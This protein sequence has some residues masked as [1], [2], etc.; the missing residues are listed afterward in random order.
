MN[1]FRAPGKLRQTTL[2]TFKAVLV[3]DTEGKRILAKY[4]GNDFATV[5][6]QIAF[7]KN[8]FDKT[9]RNPGE[10]ARVQDGAA[11]RLE[12]AHAHAFAWSGP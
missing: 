4:Y 7:E 3:L 9:K 8:L 10:R 5:K 1:P 6:E 12:D 11:G 2:Y